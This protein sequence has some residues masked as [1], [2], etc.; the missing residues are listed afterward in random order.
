MLNLKN[1]PY[2]L[3]CLLMTSLLLLAWPTSLLAEDCEN[4][5]YCLGKV[6]ENKD[7]K[8]WNIA[9]QPDG[10]G[11]PMGQGNA[12]AGARLFKN[13][14]AKCHGNVAEG[15][16]RYPIFGSY[17]DLVGNQT[18]RN[19]YE[20]L[21]QGPKQVIGSYWPYSTTVFDYIRRAMPFWHPQSLSSDD[22]YSLSAYLLHRN[23]LWGENDTLNRK[24]LPTIKMPNSECFV[25]DPRPDTDNKRCM[26][27]C[28]AD[29]GGKVSAAVLAEQSNNT[30]CMPAAWIPVELE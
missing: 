19:G 20:C 13:N 1:V 2:R 28:S 29:A 26:S 25:C 10:N 4:R 21:K 9:V 15:S 17:P 30:D 11:L 23:K 16:S 8:P 18:P 24:N 3:A 7:I 27:N 6:I 5:P 14:C 12:K 22:I